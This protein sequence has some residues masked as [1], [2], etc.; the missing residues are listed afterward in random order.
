MT[1][2]TSA[3]PEGETATAA[4]WDLTPKVSPYLDLHMMFP[5][6]EYVDSLISSGLIPFRAEDVAA[7]RLS[8]LRPTHMVDYAM[9]IYRELHGQE[10]EIPAE[11]EEQKAKVFERMEELRSGCVRFHELCG[12]EERNKLVADGKWNIDALSQMTALGVTP[13]VVE[14]YRQHAKFNFDCGDYQASRDMLENYLSLFASPPKSKDDEEDDGLSPHDQSNAEQAGQSIG[15]SAMYYLTAVD[16]DLLQ[17]L[18]GKLSCEI[19]VEDWEEASTALTAVKTAI[20]QLASTKKITALDALR[21]RTWLLHWSLF[22]FWN[23]SSKGLESMV[24]L[25]FTDLYLQAVTTNA[26]HLLRYLTSAVLLVKRRV[27]KNSGGNGRSSDARRLMKDLVRVMRDCEY[28]DPIVEFV[29]CLCVKFD[30][31]SAQAKLAECE[32]VLTADFFLCKQTALFMEEARVFVFE[33]YCR[34]HNKIDLAALGEKLAMD[35][36]Q[37]ERWIVDL[38]RNALLDA[39]IDSEER[40]VVMGGESQ[41]VYEQVMERTR[42]LNVRSGTLAQ[43]LANVLN[44]AKKEKARKE[45]AALEEDDEY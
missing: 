37:A 4:T 44:E 15:D 36:D 7:A 5:L 26:P 30:F 12:D 13:D 17:V 39:K 21:Q 41:S 24:E 43:N 29:E 11:M 10:A 40:C 9:D 2:P 18:W 42:D 38:I 32:A 8:L 22:V 33:N 16:A 31:E 1:E 28:T 25:F 20:E 23:N 19:L 14:T 27:A 34:I 35:Q 6:L 45:R 3:A